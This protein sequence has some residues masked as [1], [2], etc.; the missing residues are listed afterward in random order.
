MTE[1][2]K[3]EHRQRW[4]IM[5]KQL[6]KEYKTSWFTLIFY[7]VLIVISIGVTYLVWGSNLPT[8]IK[9]LLT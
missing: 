5:S 2:D 8:W 4:E 7:I 6:D 1:H 3:N 9:A